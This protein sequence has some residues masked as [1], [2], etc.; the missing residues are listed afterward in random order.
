VRSFPRPGPEEIERALTG[1]REAVEA[2]VRAYLPRVFG[3]CLR[4]ARSRELAEEASQEAFVRVLQNLPQEG[5]EPRCAAVDIQA[6]E[7]AIVED[8][9]LQR[10]R[11]DRDRNAR[12]P[13]EAGEII[14]ERRIGLARRR[15]K[16]PVIHE[17]AQDQGLH[18][19]TDL[20]NHLTGSRQATRG[21]RARTGEDIA[22]GCGERRHMATRSS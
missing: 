13:V 12:A 18:A 2:L 7:I 17:A 5:A 3:L 6:G 16:R 4:M 20:G 19:L 10:W 14:N 11:P 21:D 9:A 15:H 22:S 1:D 8:T